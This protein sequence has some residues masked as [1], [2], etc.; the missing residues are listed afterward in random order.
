MIAGPRLPNRAPARIVCRDRHR[1]STARVSRGPRDRPVRPI[2]KAYDIR[3]VVGEQLDARARAR[4][5]APRWPGC[6][7]RSRRR[8]RVVVVGHDMRDSSPELAA[9]FA[10]GVTGQGLDV[11]DI[12]LASTD[13][14]YFASG[15]LDVARRDVHRQPQPR[16]V[17]RDQAVPGG[18]DADRPGHRP[19][20]DPRGR[21]AGR[22]GAAA[23][24]RH[25]S[26]SAT[27]SPTTPAYLRGL[28]DLSASR[29]L[30]VVV[31][32]GNGMGR[33]HRARGARRPA[34]GRRA[35]VLR[36]RR[37]VPQPRG[38]PARPGEPGR[39]AEARGGRG[40]RH[41]AGLRR[42]RR[43][44]LRGR[45][46]RRAGEPERDH[47]RWSRSASWPRRRAAPSSTT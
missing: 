32:A 40:R 26:A 16:E 3:G 20:H 28:V 19:R 39:P 17:Q 45:R 10:E 15:T 8:P 12:G 11:V 5:S 43:P 18:R 41:R 25:A 1:C 24:G 44:L 4:A 29:P 33:L 36:A 47:R 46:A 27:C 14:L 2:V 38:Q 30:R 31:D 23:G 35:D 22:P 13:M 42:R 34:A 9:A 6:C 7:A 21:R 37:H